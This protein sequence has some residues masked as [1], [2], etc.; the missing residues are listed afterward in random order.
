MKIYPHKYERNVNELKKSIEAEERE[1][2][3]KL[4]VSTSGGRDD[5][6][7]QCSSPSTKKKTKAT[8]KS[9]GVS[10]NANNGLRR[11][12]VLD[13]PLHRQASRRIESGIAYEQSRSIYKH[14]NVLLTW[15]ANF[16]F[17]IA[18]RS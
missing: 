6:N 15:R 13:V 2:I 16:G 17:H 5:E 11:I 18:G 7:Q 14:R 10:T 8:N 12:K 4:A 3:T 1:A 9:G